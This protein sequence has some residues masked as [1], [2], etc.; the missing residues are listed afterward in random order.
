M[1]A[2]QEI[3][4]LQ[5]GIQRMQGEDATGNE[6]AIDIMA[7]ETADEYWQRSDQFNTRLILPLPNQRLMV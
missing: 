3:V 5:I 6:T 4:K 7:T 1:V 2:D